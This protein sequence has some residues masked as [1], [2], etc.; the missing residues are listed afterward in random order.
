VLLGRINAALW[1]QIE[2]ILMDDKVDKNDLELPWAG[3]YAKIEKNSNLKITF[4][5][6]LASDY[7]FA[8]L[9][10]LQNA[11]QNEAKALL[12]KRESQKNNSVSSGIDIKYDNTARG[13]GQLEPLVTAPVEGKTVEFDDIDE[14]MWAKESIEALAAENIVSGMGNKKFA[15]NLIVT[16]EQ[17]VKM[18][19]MAFN[20]SDDTAEVDQFI[21]VGSN[22]WYSKYIASAIVKGVVFGLD[23]EHFGVGQE[24]TRA[25]MATI[26]NRTARVIGIEL[27]G[28]GATVAYVDDTDIPDYAKESV[29][30]ISCAGIMSG[31]GEGMFAPRD[32]ATRAMAAKVVYLLRGGL[33]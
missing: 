16:R 23:E 14:V 5:K 28:N 10:S 21:D 2:E 31:V 29:M 24:I 11:F 6:R 25:E 19:V 30:A 20:L 8:D 18:I 13:T 7:I 26:L 27:S 3:N 4:Y 12:D 1:G 22:Q 9:K 17:F 15:P 33:K 32:K